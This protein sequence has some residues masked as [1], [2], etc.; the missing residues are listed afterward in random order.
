MS[1]NRFKTNSIRPVEAVYLSGIP[2]E[3]FSK[4]FQST[5][6]SAVQ[7][8]DSIVSNWRTNDARIAVLEWSVSNSKGDSSFR[9]IAVFTSEGKLL[10]DGIISN[11]ISKVSDTRSVSKVDPDDTKILEASARVTSLTGSVTLHWRIRFSAGISPYISSVTNDGRFFL[12]TTEI[13]CWKTDPSGI[14]PQGEPVV[15]FG[16]SG[17][18]GDIDDP[19]ESVN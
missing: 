14:P 16:Q 15:Y 11:L 3:R 8:A 13:T 7:F 6:G 1:D 4:Y 17:T 18:G 19:F 9:T 2:I 10:F 12:N 5:T